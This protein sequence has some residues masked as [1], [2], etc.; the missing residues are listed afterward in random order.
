MG[1]VVDELEVAE[2]GHLLLAVFYFYTAYGLVAYIFEDNFVTQDELFAVGAA[3]TVVAW[4]FAYL[5]VATQIIWPGSFASSTGEE[6][7]TW[8]EL[9]FCSVANFTGVGLSDVTPVLPH[10]Q[11]I[12][13]VEQIGGV[14]YIAMVISRLVALTVTRARM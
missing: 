8:Q 9:L 6:I 5:F 10:A 3:F 13:M 7:L 4:G 1:L 14:L 2:V 12:V 11:S